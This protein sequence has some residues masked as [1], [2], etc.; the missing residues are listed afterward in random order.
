MSCYDDMIHL[1]RPE[2]SHPKMPRQD[3][4]KLFAPFAALSGHDAAVHARDRVLV[5]QITLTDYTQECL[6]QTLRM[7]QK[8]DIVTITFFLPVQRNLDET[9]GEYRTVADSAM[10]LS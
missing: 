2:S 4:A 3:R 5:P 8:G 6:D 9:L 7:L 1:S 10:S